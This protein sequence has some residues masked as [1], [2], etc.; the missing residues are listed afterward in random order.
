M[1]GDRA[2]MIFTGGSVHTVDAN[3]SIAEAVA[4]SDGHILAVGSNAT[5]EATAGPSTKAGTPTAKKCLPGKRKW[6]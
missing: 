4:I 3:N 6:D 5:V 1:A 2:D